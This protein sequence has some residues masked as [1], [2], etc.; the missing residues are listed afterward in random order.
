MTLKDLKKRVPV[1]EE[2]KVI[3]RK[4]ELLN[5]GAE[6][7][8]KEIIEDGVEISVYDNGYV[9]YEEG[10]HRTVFRLHECKDYDYSAVDGRK[11]AFGADFFENENICQRIMADIQ[12][13][14]PSE[15]SENELKLPP[16]IA[17]VKAIE[18]DNPP[19]SFGCFKSING[20]TKW[21][22]KT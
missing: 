14:K 6:I 19:K 11:D 15:K 2:K 5:T 13:D 7:V 12:G 4:K 10:R 17:L 3:L 1:A 22:P 20:K 16:I 9:L 21:L 18:L 8:V